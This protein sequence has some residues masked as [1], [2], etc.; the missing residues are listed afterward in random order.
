MET[1]RLVSLAVFICLLSVS[2]ISPLC[3]ESA[4][5]DVTEFD[6]GGRE[7]DASWRAAADERIEM[8]RKGDLAVTVVDRRGRPVPDARVDVSMKRHAFLFG[9]QIQVDIIA[10]EGEEADTYRDLFLDMFNFA[11]VNPFY[12]SRWRRPDQAADTLDATLKTI[13]FFQKQD[14]PMRGHVL[15][16]KMEEAPKMSE[17]KV[18]DEAIKHI[19]RTAGH[20]TIAKA[21]IEWDV[22]NEPFANS[23][24]LKKLGREKMPDYFKLVNKH[25]PHAK[26][27]LN[28]NQLISGL[29]YA[30]SEK[31]FEYIIDLVEYL[32]DAGTPIHGLGCQGHHVGSLADINEVVKRLDRLA[33]L[34]LDIEITEYDIKLIPAVPKGTHQE[35][36]RAPSS[37][38]PEL[39]ALEGEYMGDF[40]TACFSHP[41]V[42]AFIMWGFWDGKHWLFNA[43]LF[44]EDWTLKPAGKAYKNLVFDKWWTNVDGVTSSAGTFSTRGFLGRYEISAEKDGRKQTVT[45]DLIH[46]G[47]QLK[48]VLP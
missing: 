30:T 6:Y 19:N 28:E 7:P 46:K 11:T 16:W 12:Y 2:S 13:S 45:T 40:L 10:A 20:P 38:S 29:H 1:Y 43:P 47:L 34:D 25:A 23:D 42:T 37:T 3:A 39:E 5:I 18:Y 32:K 9:S 31:R 4:D 48:I 14:I 35:K 24:I 44:Y 27:F 26:L 17:K 33:K 8:Y 21:L 36:W 15:V 41:S 22:Q